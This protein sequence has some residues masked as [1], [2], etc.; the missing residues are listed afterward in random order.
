MEAWYENDA[1]HSAM[2]GTQPKEGILA[3][4]PS[5]PRTLH[6]TSIDGTESLSSLPVLFVTSKPC[7]CLTAQRTNEPGELTASA[8]HLRA[9]SPRLFGSE[10]LA[11]IKIRRWR[12]C[13]HPQTAGDPGGLVQL[14]SCA[15]KGKPCRWVRRWGCRH[16]P[17]RYAIRFT[18]SRN[19][20]GWDKAP[21]HKARIDEE[22]R[23]DS[24]TL[25]LAQGLAENVRAYANRQ[26]V[27]LVLGN[28]FPMF[29][30]DAAGLTYV[31]H[32]IEIPLNAAL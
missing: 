23:W 18:R 9:A 1:H 3:N 17:R 15:W 25:R 31:E 13:H 21:L 6:D 30:H 32:Q 28:I 5:C 8:D 4:R 12:T 24:V 22:F 16:P 11:R 20:G 14:A 10:S 2:Q 19:P 29:V 7:V 27:K 26:V